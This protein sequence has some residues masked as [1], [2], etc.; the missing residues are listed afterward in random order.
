MEREAAKQ[1]RRGIHTPRLSK[2]PF[3]ETEYLR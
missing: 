2:S 3:G 1:I